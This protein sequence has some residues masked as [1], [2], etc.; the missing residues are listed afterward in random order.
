[1]DVRA[2][3]TVKGRVQGVGFR[4][5]T[6]QQARNL[7]LTGTVENL[8]NGDVKVLVE[9]DK[10]AVQAFMKALRVGPALANV[11]DVIVDFQKYK[12]EFATF[13]IV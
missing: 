2:E 13:R 6:A 12:N 1:M 11:Q 5:F 9:G 3:I 8:F 4:F 10:G 7:G